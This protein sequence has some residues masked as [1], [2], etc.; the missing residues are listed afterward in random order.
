MTQEVVTQYYRAPELLLGAN[1]YS[2]AI[3]VWSVGCI[4]AELLGRRI[5][6]QA[7]SPLKQVIFIFLFQMKIFI[8]YIFSLI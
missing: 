1:H 2:Y 4:F 7:S 8:K 6:F 3:D 5:L